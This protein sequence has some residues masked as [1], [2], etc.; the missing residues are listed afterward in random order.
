M[1][2]SEKPKR[3]TR[4]ADTSVSDTV[5]S[6]KLGQAHRP[7]IRDVSRLASVSR[8]TVSRVLSEPSLVLPETRE[9][10]IRAIA[11]LGYVPDRAAGGLAS[12]R[13]GFIG[14]VLPTLTNANFSNVA[15]GLTEVLREADYHLLIGYTDYDLAEE[16]RQIRGLLAR[17]S[18]A[19]VLTGAIHTRAASTMLLR[20]DVP[21]IEVADLPPRPIH[22][23]VGF[24]N[25]Q[26]GRIAAQY[27][28]RRGL[29]RIGAIGGESTGDVGDYRGEERIRGFEDELKIAGLPTDLVLRQG[30]APVSFSHGAKAVATL[31]ARDSQIEGIFAV[32]DLV[33]VGVIMECKRHNIMIPAQISVIGFG[34]F[35][36]AREMEPRLTTIHVDFR[37]LGRRTGHLILDSLTGKG[38]GK[39]DVIDVGLSL[40]ERESVALRTLDD[41]SNNMRL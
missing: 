17:R 10:V 3:R 12:R 26:A 18:E 21:V 28:L 33:A 9:R 15:H 5:A 4:S 14:L 23:A 37:E 2:T 31:L 38:V 22:R 19:I 27:L 6:T 29:R 24:S 13:T 40:L 1:T 20:S 11:D 36:I 39:D 35:E 25:Y 30:Q 41:A 32:S 16:E 34:D 7:T 8:M